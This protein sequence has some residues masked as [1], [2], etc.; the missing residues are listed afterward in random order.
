[1]TLTDGTERVSEAVGQD[2]E[3]EGRKRKREREA[4]AVQKVWT[5]WTNTMERF[6][7]SCNEAGTDEMRR[8]KQ[9]AC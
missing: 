5:V 9:G 6:T 7:E 2:E 4:E 3:K 1:M 8:G